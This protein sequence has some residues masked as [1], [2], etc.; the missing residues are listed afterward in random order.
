MAHEA[1]GAIP[2][3]A[4]RRHRHALAAMRHDCFA[5]AYF[6]MITKRYRAGTDS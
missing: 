3:Q 1:A 6:V 5:P 2:R 4:M